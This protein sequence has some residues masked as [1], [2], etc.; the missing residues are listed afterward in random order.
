[1]VLLLLETSVFLAMTAARGS[2]TCGVGIPAADG[3][4]GA[5]AAEEA[6]PPMGP[7]ISYML[8][9]FNPIVPLS[10]ELDV[11]PNAAEGGGMIVELLP[12]LLLVALLCPYVPE[13]LL[14]AP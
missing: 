14:P 12:L 9:L 7:P 4:G 8:L 6:D 2:K 3:S 11:I 10:I 1:M 13:E 5:G